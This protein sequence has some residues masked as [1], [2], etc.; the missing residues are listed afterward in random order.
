MWISVDETLAWLKS[1]SSSVGRLG[2]F[3]LFRRII[4]YK[5]FFLVSNSDK[6]IGSVTH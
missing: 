1:Y 5:D 6:S 4:I 2:I 3:T